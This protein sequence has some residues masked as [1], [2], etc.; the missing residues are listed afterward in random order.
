MKT[1][2]L[3]GRLDHMQRWIDSHACI[4]RSQQAEDRVTDPGTVVAGGTLTY[5]LCPTIGS[6]LGVACECG[7]V[8]DDVT[9]TAVRH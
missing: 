9:E 3:L 8:L 4:I 5:R 7:A 6:M 2:R 1:E